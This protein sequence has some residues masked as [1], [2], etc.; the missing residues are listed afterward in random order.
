M[1]I[2]GRGVVMISLKKVK[3]DS[4]IQITVKDDVT[5]E[6]AQKFKDELSEKLSD[7]KKAE[8]NI[9]K[10]EIINLVIIQLLKAC[11]LTFSKQ[12][13]P[14]LWVSTDEKKFR[15]IQKKTGLELKVLI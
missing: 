13:I 7:C 14:Y 1:L 8:I 3:K 2:V 5:I 4:L 11:C 9:Q 15:E 10:L 12:G 6:Q